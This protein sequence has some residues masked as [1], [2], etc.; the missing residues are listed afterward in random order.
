MQAGTGIAEII[1]LE[2]SR[3]GKHTL[4]EARKKI[5]LVD[6]KGLVTKS[7]YDSLQEFK[8]LY[9]HEHEPCSNLLSAIKAL[10]PT[11]L[12][13]TS[14]RG[15]TFTKEALEEIASYQDQPIIFALSNPTSQSECT[16]EE[17]YKYTK[18]S[19]ATVSSLSFGNPTLIVATFPTQAKT[20]S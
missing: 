8:K 10:K 3:Q 18:V 6:S 14:G 19:S 11:V 20:A 16:A 7:R 9:A 5:Y 1:A 13:G 4:E 15:G 17:A 2:I 12:I